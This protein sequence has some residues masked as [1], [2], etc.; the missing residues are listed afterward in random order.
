M[1]WDEVFRQHKK[2][3]AIFKEGKVL[4]SLIFSEDRRRARLNE[5]KGNELLFCFSPSMMKN[6]LDAM[7]KAKIEKTKIRV[8]RKFG[9][10]DWKD[11]G[12]HQITEFKTGVDRRGEISYIF[13]LK[14]CGDVGKNDRQTIKTSWVFFSG[15]S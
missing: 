10:D 1:K 11:I 13:L 14:Q 2:M 4:K 3:G 9:P 7:Q 15:R 8:F 5:A 6:D 12:F